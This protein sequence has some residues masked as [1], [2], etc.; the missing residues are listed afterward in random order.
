MKAESMESIC[1]LVSAGGERDAA[2]EHI[3]KRT[4]AEKTRDRLTNP[5]AMAITHGSGVQLKPRT[6]ET[7]NATS[8][9][10]TG[11]I[12]Q[13]SYSIKAQVG[14]APYNLK[15]KFKKNLKPKDRRPNI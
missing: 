15:I 1:A 7:A 5:K 14:G 3:T 6:P 9:M 2:A 4:A 13:L 12:K 10:M 11:R 8:A